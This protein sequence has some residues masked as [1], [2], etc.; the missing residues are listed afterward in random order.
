MAF[1]AFDDKSE[2]PQPK[3]VIEVL[4]DSSALWDELISIMREEYE[5]LAEDW[6]FSGKKWGWSL[7]LKYK[8]RA[9]LYLTPQEGLFSV[10]F[11]LGQ[12]AVDAA[13]REGLPQSVLSN[14][15][16]SQKFAEGRGVRF[17]VRQVEDVNH[18][19]QVA[20]IKMAN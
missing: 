1:S 20:L 8:K 9:V 16:S 10:G 3:E 11:A 19:V 17:D 2:E 4:A 14:I 12:K 5:P 15:D 7:R 13:H 18:V 6:V